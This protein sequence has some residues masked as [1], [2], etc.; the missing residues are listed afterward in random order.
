MRT[1]ARA[2]RALA[3][4]AMIA[5][6]VVAA[7]PVRARAQDPRTGAPAPAASRAPQRVT[8][9][10]VV[11]R[12]DTA[13]P[14][15]GVWVTLHRVGSDTAG[16]LDSMRVGRDGRYAFRYERTG[17]PEAVYFVSGTYGGIAYFSEPLRG[18]FVQGQAAEIMVYDTTSSVRGVRVQGR[19]LVVS[20][21]RDGRRHEVIEVYEIS[22]DSSQTVVSPDSAHPVWSGVVPP[23]AEQFQVSRGDVGAAAVTL[24]DGRV[25]LFAPI[26]PGIRQLSFSYFVPASEF[27]LKIPMLRR[28]EVLEVLV[29]D[30]GARVSG[31][32]LVEEE[33]A[34]LEGRQ[35]KRFLAQQVDSS[36]VVRI[37]MGEQA[38]SRALVLTIVATVLG[39]IMLAALGRA[40]WKRREHAPA[41]T[42]RPSRAAAAAAPPSA[43]PLRVES[44]SQSLVREIAALDAEFEQRLPAA[45]APETAAYEARR[46]SLKREL[47]AALARERGQA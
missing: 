10:V 8:G 6:A 46:D 31:A 23:E 19:H 30:P 5:L 45:A 20:A 17:D 18:A 28:T 13:L 32:G 37:E 27:P 39:I 11:P 29:E 3:P 16:P 12:G 14:V 35:F 15:A 7:T 43:H 40:F 24:R 22:N 26:S 42:V 44:S 41:D 2:R 21:Q 25:S 9:Q 34:M 1:I 38:A 47:A 36:A 33:P 4:A